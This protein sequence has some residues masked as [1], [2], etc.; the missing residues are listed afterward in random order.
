MTARRIGLVTVLLGAL[1]APAG[2]DAQG[3]ARQQFDDGDYAGGRKTLLDALDA[4]DLALV[5]RARI[6]DAL[7]RFYEEV[8]GS[9]IQP[10]R[11]WQ[12]VAEM[13]LAAD[14]PLA[15][16]AREQLA[17]L[18]ANEKTYAAPHQAVRYANYPPTDLD[19]TGGDRQQA[20]RDEL[21][22]R[23]AD[24]RAAAEQYPDY[25][26]MA[27]LHHTIGLNYMWLKAYR[28]AATAFARALELR[29]AI[30][31][32]HPT[33]THRS[34]C[35]LEWIHQTVPAIAWWVI[36][37]IAAAWAGAFV[38]LRRWRKL[39]WTH[40]WVAALL[41][42]G[43]CAVF[44]GTIALVKDLEFPEPTEAFA[45]PIE[46]HTAPGQTGDEPLMSLF[47]YGL[48]AVGGCVAFTTVSSAIRRGL[49]RLGANLAVSLVLSTA[50]MTLAYL[51]HVSRPA[52]YLR[53]AP[54]AAATLTSTF[55]FH[56]KTIEAELPEPGEESP[57]D[58]EEPTP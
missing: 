13:P 7:A 46:I 48:A 8:V 38:A 5:E 53:T 35:I 51:E 29:P 12:A 19:P 57:D 24:L 4:P 58:A 30:D 31:L 25:P 26:H 43:W 18:A 1:V 3:R 22:A 39:T 16:G 10:K 52:V 14:H 49:W 21:L 44:F 15:V 2:A 45:T 32:I 36:G 41:L 6:R 56:V 33:S 20:R 54:G 50:L 28:P 34:T 9:E 55:N 27:H 17:R 23:I 37:A 40:A 42:A 47:W 11:H